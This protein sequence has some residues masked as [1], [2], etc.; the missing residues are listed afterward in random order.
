M[1]PP[2]APSAA[3]YS[4]V[5]PFTRSIRSPLLNKKYAPTTLA[6]AF[7]ICSKI[8]EMAVGIMFRKPWKNPRKTPK[9]AITSTVGASILIEY[10]ASCAFSMVPAIKS[11]PKYIMQKNINPDRALTKSAQRKYLF[12][13]LN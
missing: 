11:A 10:E 8:W 9:K 6:M 7:I 1:V 2:M 13:F 4:S 5:V 3:E 12:A